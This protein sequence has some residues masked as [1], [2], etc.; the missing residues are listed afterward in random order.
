MNY[1]R[2]LQDTVILKK[3]KKK[4]KYGKAIFEEEKEIKAKIEEQMKLIRTISGEEIVATA[5]IYID[6]DENIKIGDY[7]G[8]N[9]VVFITSMKDFKNRPMIKEVWV[10]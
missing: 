3:G 9:K 4:D 10:K 6:K 8:S 2:W 5:V 7:I 1:N